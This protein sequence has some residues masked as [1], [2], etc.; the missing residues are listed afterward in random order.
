M[1]TLNNNDNEPMNSILLLPP[2]CFFVLVLGEVFLTTN[3][4]GKPF[5]VGDWVLSL[6]GFF[7]QGLLIPLV[8]Y[9]VAASVLPAFFGDYE[10]VYPLGWWEGFLISFVGIDFIYYWQHRCFHQVGFLWKFH[11]CHHNS[12][13]V[14]VWATARNTFL[15]NFLFVY[16]LLTP[17]LAFVF[18]QKESFLFGSM[19]TACL[20]LL[21]HSNVDFYEV[22]ILRRLVAPLSKVIVM[23]REHHIHHDARGGRGNFGANFIIWDRLFGTADLGGKLPDNYTNEPEASTVKQLLYPFV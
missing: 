1:F 23:P 6:S 15:T 5:R 16:T 2:A 17:P 22:P 12:P 20:D 4:Q 18:D 19:C 8:G 3:A 10:G 21:K 14:N 13:K 9:W 11:A 7:A